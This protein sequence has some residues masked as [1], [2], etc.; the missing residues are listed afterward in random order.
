MLEK[1]DVDLSDIT[2]SKA[3]YI[4]SLMLGK[5]LLGP[6]ITF[7]QPLEAKLVQLLKSQ[8]PIDTLNP[9]RI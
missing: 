4:V 8:P 5:K 1:R 2:L 3:A 6:K 9:E 7:W